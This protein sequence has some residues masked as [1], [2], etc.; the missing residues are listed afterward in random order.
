MLPAWFYE[1]RKRGKLQA[2]AM[3]Q[4]KP[5]GISVETWLGG[6]RYL[7]PDNRTD[8]TAFN[9][10]QMLRP[11]RRAYGERTVR[12]ITAFEAQAWTLKHPAQVRWLRLAWQEAVRFGPAEVDVW[13]G[14]VKPKRKKPKPRA[15]TLEEL[16][17]ILARCDELNRQSRDTFWA[18]FRN[19]LEVMAYSGARRG[20]MIGIR[21]GHVDLQAH[22]FTVTE[23]GG[24]TRDLVLAGRA[25]GAM[26]RQFAIRHREG[27]RL[28]RPVHGESEAPPGVY[29]WLSR[30]WRPMS[31]ATMRHAWDE[32]RGDFPFGAHSLKHFAVTWLLEQGV[33]KEDVAVQVGHTDLEG[34]PYPN[35]V[36]RV[37]NHPKPE[38]ALRRLHAALYPTRSDDAS[39]AGDV[40]RAEDRG[41]GAGL[42]RSG[43]CVAGGA[44]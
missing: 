37:Y 36:E 19:L 41:A 24:K 40:P 6:F 23:K 16:A 28:A 15:P 26:E 10:V 11:F 27:W 29:V 42:L 17:G 7:R 35:L 34:R 4:I 3:R 25:L 2:R 21:R 39:S 33:S 14:V 43:A 30:T 1:D 12:S 38:E 20:G 18:Q 8:D 22:R 32:V 5:E 31:A 13:A 44:W 9:D